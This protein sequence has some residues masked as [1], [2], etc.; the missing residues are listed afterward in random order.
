MNLRFNKFYSP[1]EGTG[2]G[3]SEVQDT[4]ELLNVDET[5][6]PEPPLEI[7]V[8]KE[9][10]LGEGE[11]ELEDGDPDKAKVQKEEKEEVD[12]LAEL[13]EEL[14]KTPSEE[15][16]LEITTPVRRKEILTKYPNLFKDFP[17]LEKAYYREQQFTETFPTVQDARVAAD[18]ARIL[19]HVERQVMDGDISMFLKAAKD[20]NQEAFNKIA[21]NYLPTLKQVD[22][23]AYYHVLGNVV[24]DTIITMVREGKAL[25]DQG[26]PL[27]AAANVLNQFIFG[28]Q[29]FTP[30][31]RLTKQVDPQEQ[32]RQQASQQEQQ[33]RVMNQFVQVRDDLQVR[34]DNVLKATI[35]GHIDPNKSM[36]EYVKGHAVK[37]AFDNLETLISKDMRFRSL[38]DKLWEKAFHSNFDKESTDRIKSA[39]LSKAKT[40]LPSVIQKARRDAL[41]DMPAPVVE[42]EKPTRRSPIAHGSSGSPSTKFRKASDIPRGMSTLEVLMKD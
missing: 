26:A 22:Q 34:A 42:D 11:G 31:Q 12:E 27:V 23:Q 28:S 9:K 36:S 38:L 18:K 24:K 17:Y 5:P 7:K 15:D 10:E 32:Q 6:A 19:D 41:K 29:Q 35:D 20:E 40:L 21:D 13:E 37:E 39:Y 2:T 33:N 4:F 3:S 1:D 16:L 30:P 25:G 8:P 14:T